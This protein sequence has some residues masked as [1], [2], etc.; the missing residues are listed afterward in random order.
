MVTVMSLKDGS[1]FVL[2]SHSHEM[3]S[4]YLLTPTLLP[5][6]NLGCRAFFLD[7]GKKKTGKKKNM[8]KQTNVLETEYFLKK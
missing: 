1:V 4:S 2:S 8:Q 3:M 6:Y 5:R 7:S